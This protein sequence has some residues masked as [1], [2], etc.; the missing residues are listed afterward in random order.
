MATVVTVPLRA[1]PRPA[2]DRFRRVEQ[3]IHHQHRCRHAAGGGH[4]NLE[5]PS[6]G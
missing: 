2:L 6:R 3:R 4:P 5:L 1:A